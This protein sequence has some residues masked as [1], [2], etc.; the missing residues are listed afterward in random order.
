M[1]ASKAHIN[2]KLTR[3]LIDP[4]A[5][6]LFISTT[7]V[8]HDKLKMNVLNE[9]VVVGMPIGMSIVCKNVYRNV[10]LEIDGGKMKWNF[11]PLYL[12]EFDA[13]LGMDGL[14]HY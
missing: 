7:F 6:Y 12:N 10:W 3:I 13:I 1:I 5:T 14:S 9:P 2:G 8:M 11:T 4:G